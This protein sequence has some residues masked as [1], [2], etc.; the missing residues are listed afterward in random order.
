MNKAVLCAAV[1]AGWSLAALYGLYFLRPWLFS[2]KRAEPGG[3][4]DLQ[5][6]SLIFV[7]PAL[8]NAASW[9]YYRAA[10][11]KARYSAIHYFDYSCREASLEAVAA[12]LARVVEDVAGKHPRKK[13]VIIGAS[14]GGLVARASLV[15]VKRPETLG[16]LITLA[17]P[18]Q[19]TRLARLVPKKLFPLLRD[20]AYQSRAIRD[21]EEKESA[22]PPAGFPRTAF[23]S[24]LDE[25]VHPASALCPPPG[26]GWKTEKTM[27]ISHMHIMLHQPTI[28]RVV[29]ELAGFAASEE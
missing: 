11:Q 19:G 1:Q 12:R 25:L 23:Y 2:K 17:C 7:H 5:R 20:I 4:R 24:E 13:T 8:Q 9:Y 21:L 26:Q 14:L 22:A 16:G 15:R 28:N 29:R 18:H 10:L 6:P 3:L 27:P